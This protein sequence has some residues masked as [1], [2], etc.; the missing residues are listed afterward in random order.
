VPGEPVVGDADRLGQV[1][2]NLL[3]NAI[4]FTPAGGR[5][6]ASAVPESDGWTIEVSDTGI[7]IP[8]AEQDR[9][10]DEFYRASNSRGAATPGTGLG[11]AISRLIVHRHGG[12]LALVSEQDRGTTAVL[13][14]PASG[15]TRVAR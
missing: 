14:L 9:L 2:D 15:R 8:A 12:D 7:G 6:C 1:L 3:S 13:R 10:F 5:V 4:K 11:L